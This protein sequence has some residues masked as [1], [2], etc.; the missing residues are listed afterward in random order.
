VKGSEDTIPPTCVIYI[1][2][3][4]KDGKKVLALEK[5]ILYVVLQVLQVVMGESMVS[6]STLAFG[7]KVSALQDQN[8][9]AVYH[10]LHC[11]ALATSEADMSVTISREWSLPGF[12]TGITVASH[13]AS[14]TELYVHI[15]L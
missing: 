14:G 10:A 7:E 4:E 6:E 5:G 1:L 11:L 9:M 12:G 13:Q 3:V 8:K 15:R 2:Q